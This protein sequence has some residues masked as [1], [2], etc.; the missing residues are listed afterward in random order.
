MSSFQGLVNTP[1]GGCKA[2]GNNQWALENTD[3]KAVRAIP[4]HLLFRRRS[5]VLVA[6]LPF[7]R[8]GFDGQL[9]D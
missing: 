2:L 5:I 7:R 1:E 8:F 3:W 9:I 4:S 6:W